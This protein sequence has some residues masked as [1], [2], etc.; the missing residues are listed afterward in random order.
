MILLI[1]GATDIARTLLIEQWLN[2]HPVWRHIA[3]EELTGL[4]FLQAVSE[5]EQRR[6][7]LSIACHCANEVAEEGVSVI[8]SHSAATDLL[9][10]LKAE[11]ECPLLTIH[12]G[13]EEEAAGFDHAIPTLNRSASDVALHLERIIGKASA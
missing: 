10:L 2:A 7:S 9:D 12:L 4:P 1:S 5:D 8:L 3:V 6:L 11:I 13:A